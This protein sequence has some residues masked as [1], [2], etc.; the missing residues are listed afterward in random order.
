[1]LSLGKDTMST[2]HVHVSAHDSAVLNRIFNPNLPYGDVV[3]EDEVDNEIGSKTTFIRSAI[4]GVRHDLFVFYNKLILTS[5][6]L[7]GGGGGG[8]GGFNIIEDK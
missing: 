7:Y 8:G 2:E 6:I 5:P 4:T 1:M 3:D